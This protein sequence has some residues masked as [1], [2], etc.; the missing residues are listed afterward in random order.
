MRPIV[1]I[2]LRLGGRCSDW[3]VG[4]HTLMVRRIA[5]RCLYFEETNLLPRLLL[6]P[7][8]GRGRKRIGGYIAA[9][10]LFVH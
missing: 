7:W 3:V 8:D 4:P 5:I 1:V 6:L 2:S 10:F 9:Y